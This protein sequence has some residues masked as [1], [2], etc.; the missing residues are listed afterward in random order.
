M[1]FVK[2]NTCAAIS[3]F[4][5][6]NVMVICLM[7]WEEIDLENYFQIF[8][9]ISLRR[10]VGG[11]LKIC[12]T[13]FRSPLFYGSIWLKIHYLLQKTHPSGFYSQK[14]TQNSQL[15]NLGQNDQKSK[16]GLKS[17]FLLIDCLKTWS[18]CSLQ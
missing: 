4:P 6:V 14:S 17:Y 8:I 15:K 3:S 10:Q 7:F 16:N 18:D 5:L 1:K 9:L 11:I 12:G 13:F 2:K